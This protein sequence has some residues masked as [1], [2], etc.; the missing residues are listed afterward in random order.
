MRNRVRVRCAAFCIA[1]STMIG[2]APLHYADTDVGR[3]KGA[4]VVEWISEDLFMFVPNEQWP[5]SFTRSN[6]E[7]ISPGLMVT[8]GGSVPRPLWAIR[9]YSPWGYAPAFIVHDWL[10]QQKH[11][12]AS[13]YNYK[14]AA[15]IMSEAIKT[16]VE[17]KGGPGRGEK[18]VIYSMHEAV[19]SPIAAQL[20]ENG[21]C[22]RLED[23]PLAADVEPGRAVGRLRYT[24]DFGS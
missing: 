19:S 4:I 13:P 3:L 18:F 17:D 16:M 21:E 7:V 6:G 14:D 10:Y 23:V 24:I 20:W 2:C 12:A 8:D 9:N 5:F 22:H 11:C 15:W 1:A